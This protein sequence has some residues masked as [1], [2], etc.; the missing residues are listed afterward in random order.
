MVTRPTARD[1]APPAATYWS[2]PAGDVPPSRAWL[3][4][5]A[6]VVRH[7]Y[8]REAAEARAPWLDLGGEG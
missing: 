4:D 6:R 3:V 5:T 2:T 1:L 7:R 8:V